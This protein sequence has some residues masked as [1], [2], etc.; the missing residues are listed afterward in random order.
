MEK[1]D[2]N[3]EMPK[4][5]QETSEG[6]RRLLKLLAAGTGT[7]AAASILPMRWTRPLVEM[8]VLPAHAQLS[9]F[10]ADLSVTM[11]W[12]NSVTNNDF[13]LHIVD[14]QDA[15]DVFGGQT[16]SA[17]L[18]HNG[19][20]A[21]AMTG[22]ETAGNTAPGVVAAGTYQIYLR[23]VFG[24]VRSFSSLTV[25]VTVSGSVTNFNLS[26][27]FFTTAIP[28]SRRIADVTFPAGS[29]TDRAGQLYP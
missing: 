20:A 8:G 23:N 9:V 22:A 11:D 26:P 7:F 3:A 19:D 28:E 15:T 13:E 14:P 21:Q 16:T 24:N 25:A 2:R 10:S 29:L 6:R 4:T 27:G 17:T 12:V 18:S 5:R 1:F